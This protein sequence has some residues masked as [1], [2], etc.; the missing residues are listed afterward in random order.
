[1][2]ISIDL[3]DTEKRRDLAD[4]ANIA[5]PIKPSLIGLSREQLKEKLSS[6]GIA[7]KQLKMRVAQLWHWLYVRGVS[8]FADMQNSAGTGKGGTIT[9]ALF[10]E[11][12][13]GK[14]KW[15]H[16]D[17]FGWTSPHKP[18]LVQKGGSGQGVELLINFLS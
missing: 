16:L 10:I 9:A 13:I 4:K 11:K 5:T 17:I 14:T 8:D 7:D 15:A 18:T 3:K 1:M 12:F 2:A 6:I